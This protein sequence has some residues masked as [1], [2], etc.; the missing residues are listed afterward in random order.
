MIACLKKRWYYLKRNWSEFLIPVI[1]VVIFGF[2]LSNNSPREI[3]Q[4][5]VTDIPNKIVILNESTV[6]IED[7]L[8]TVSHN[9]KSNSLINSVDVIIRYSS[10]FF[11]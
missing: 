7:V 1:T 5:V 4:D 2:I 10:K 11:L 8:N 6:N 3:H 9:L